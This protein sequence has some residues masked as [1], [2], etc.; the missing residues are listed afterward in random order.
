MER[1][2]DTFLKPSIIESVWPKI[3]QGMLVTVELGLAVVITGLIAG[4]LLALIRTAQIRPLNV[5]IV[6]FVDI[7][8]AVPPLVIVLIVY[9]GLPNVGLTLP[10]FAV[11]WLVLAAVLAAFAEEIFWA[12]IA[13]IRRGQWDAARST[14]LGFT[15][16]LLYVILPQTVRMVLPPL[17]NRTIAI[18]KNTAL[19]TVIG[20][21]ELLNQATTAV[22]F[23]SNATPLTLAAIGYLIIF[24]PVVLFGGWLEHRFAY[25][26][27]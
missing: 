10:S 7:L 13:S 21:P 12:G 5:V 16:T 2:V 17:V 15:Q 8:R 25:R 14:G 11:L 9:F 26:K 24:V 4:L 22:S 3:L 27:A 23:L 6:I 1:F 18:T 20:V 19:G